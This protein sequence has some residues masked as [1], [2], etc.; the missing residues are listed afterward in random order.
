MAN[1][2]FNVALGEVK[3]FCKLDG[4]VNDALLLVL[5]ETTGLE[6]DATLRDYD[7]LLALLAGTSNEATFTNYARKVLSSGV[8]ITVDD[9]NNWVDIDFPDQ[10]WV[11]AGPG[12]AVSRLLVCYDPDTTVGTDATV[13]PLTSHDFVATPDGTNLVAEVA[14]SGFFRAS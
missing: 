10:T 7:D 9:T 4:G 13:V 1:L 12:N 3:K 14:A 11:T 6:A 2:V 5:L 8:T